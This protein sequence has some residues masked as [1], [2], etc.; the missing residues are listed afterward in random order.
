[1]SGEDWRVEFWDTVNRYVVACGGDPSR[2]YGN[3][4]RQTAVAEIE[5]VLRRVLECEASEQAAPGGEG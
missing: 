1:M 4:A 2:V 3:T 5:A